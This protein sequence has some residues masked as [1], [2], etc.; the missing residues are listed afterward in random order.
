[1]ITGLNEEEGQLLKDVK[2]EE[3]PIEEYKQHH[4]EVLVRCQ[5]E[6]ELLEYLL[7][8]QEY[9]SVTAVRKEGVSEDLIGTKICVSF[10]VSDV[11]VNREV[12]V[13]EYAVKKMIGNL[14]HESK[15]E[16]KKKK[17]EIVEKDVCMAEK[18]EKSSQRIKNECEK[19]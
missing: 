4:D 19:L 15:F 2:K 18:V 12:K 9:E 14:L 11:L 1:M 5:R 17:M 13:D 7:K 3:E 8:E 6:I 16:D 10:Q